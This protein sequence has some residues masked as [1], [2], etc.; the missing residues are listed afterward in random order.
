VD[1]NTETKGFA[2]NWKD[3]GVCPKC[4][5]DLT[6]YGKTEHDGDVMVY[7]FTCSCGFKGREVYTLE[8]LH[9]TNEAGLME[10]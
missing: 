10:L 3:C 5:E 9:M 2:G 8:F 1:K 7:P 6:Q 4:E